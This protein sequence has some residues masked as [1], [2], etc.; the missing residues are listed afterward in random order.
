[1]ARQMRRRLAHGILLGT[2]AME[3]CALVLGIED[4][5]V[6]AVPGPSEASVA[7]ARDASVVDARDAAD[8]DTGDGDT[9]D[10]D[11]G[12]V[13]TGDVDTGVVTVAQVTAGFSHTCARFSNGTVKCWGRNADGQLGLGNM[14]PMLLAPPMTPVD[15]GPGLSAREIA[16][17]GNHTCALL[18]NRTIKCWG[19]NAEGQLGLGVPGNRGD[20]AFE[21]G[22]NLPAVNL[23]TGRTALQII[24]GDNHTCA[25]LDNSTVK[26]WGFNLYGQL[27]VGTN[28]NTNV[29]GAEVNL[30]TSRTALQI[31]AGDNH[32]CARLDNSTV[33][34]WGFNSYGQLGLGDME[35]RGDQDGGMGANLLT[36]D[37]GTN[38]TARELVAGGNHTCAR[39]DDF[40]VKCWGFA[41]TGQ[42]GLGDTRNRGGQALEM[43]T[44]LPVVDLGTSRTARELVAGNNH[45]CARLDNFTI[46]CWGH[47]LYG[48]L[49]LGDTMNRGGQDGG[50][51][52]NLPTVDLGTSRTV[53]EITAGGDHTCALL[54]DFTVKCWGYNDQGQ[55][56]LSHTLNRG[57]QPGQMGNSLPAILFP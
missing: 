57:G 50:M 23:G 25:R 4:V 3:G 10:V 38:R 8:G 44:N 36:V 33:K 5:P 47:N 1:M 46:K 34:C 24:A 29:P 39:L 17:G 54:D 42:L 6:P 18:D 13:D 43:G 16:A 26:C 51:G 52:A 2:I 15:L 21:M 49:G 20:E 27:G 45:T 56:G 41:F 9:G 40:T 32:T 14:M 28:V 12:D 22:A 37:L 31:T 7:D 11:T 53:L 35:R 55:L 30:G 19:R 48:Q